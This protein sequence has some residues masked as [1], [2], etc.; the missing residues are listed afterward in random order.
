LW[1]GPNGYN[2]TIFSAVIPNVQYNDT[3]LYKLRKTFYYAC[4]LVDTFYLKVVPGTALTVQPAYPIC[5]GTSEHLFASAPDSVG[6]LWTPS[7][8][9]S[10]NTI[11]DPIAT[12]ADYTEYKLVITNRYGC[13]DSALLII[14]VYKKPVANAGPDK[15]I[16][17]GDTV[18]LDGSVTGTSV[19][20]QWSPPAFIDDI[21]S[22]TPKV[23]PPQEA[24][25]TLTVNSN[26]GCGSSVSSVKVIVYNDIYVPN[27]FTPNNDGKNDKFG[28]I[29]PD[30]Y[31]RFRLMVY[32]RWGQLV[33]R[34]TDM[35]KEWDGRFN[36]TMQP[37][38]AYVYNLEILSVSNKKI[39]K[40]GSV[41]LLR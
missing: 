25:Y 13:K 8:G 14:D 36:G 5:E 1:T 37:A 24:T 34:T 23:Y 4:V 18:I 31:K 17:A 39:T 10:N 32:N 12:P 21:H 15:K 40:K 7:A 35:N 3:G 9:L 33:F 41:T 20:F 16:N 11:P 30:T 6:F 19:D 2:S 28:A 26:L 22:V 27:A 29:G 38:G